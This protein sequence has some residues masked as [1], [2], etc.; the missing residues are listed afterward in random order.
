VYS[1]LRSPATPS[2]E[3]GFINRF[4][5]N[6]L[7]PSEVTLTS[8]LVGLRPATT[9]TVKYGRD[10]PTILSMS[11]VLLTCFKPIRPRS[12]TDSRECSLQ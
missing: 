3:P 4:L 8:L 12:T 5:L 9:Q 1:L 6:V 10:C 7:L 11:H 2:C